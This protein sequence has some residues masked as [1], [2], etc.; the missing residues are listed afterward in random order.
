[1]NPETFEAEQHA[2]EWANMPP[3]TTQ[4][5]K[6]IEELKREQVAVLAQNYANGGKSPK[7]TYLQIAK[8]YIDVDEGY[9]SYINE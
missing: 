4:N 6:R 1:M 8:R 7:K 9:A 5:L 3:L 2:L